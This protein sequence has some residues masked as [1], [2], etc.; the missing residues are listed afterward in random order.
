MAERL[1]TVCAA[2]LTASCWNA[3]FM[4]DQSDSAGTVQMPV[5]ELLHL[6]LEHPS[7]FGTGLLLLGRHKGT[8]T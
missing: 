7:N 6:A 1:V 3:E 5:G 4:C 8:R 2:C